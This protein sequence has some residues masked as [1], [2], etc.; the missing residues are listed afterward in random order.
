MALKGD[1][2][3]GLSMAIILLLI[4]FQ[5]CLSTHQRKLQGGLYSLHKSNEIYHNHD[6]LI[7]VLRHR[8]HKKSSLK[9]HWFQAPRR[10]S[11]FR[12]LRDPLPEGNSRAGVRRGRKP[13]L[14]SP[15]T[16]PPIAVGCGKGSLPM[17]KA[18]RKPRWLDGTSISKGAITPNTHLEWQD[19]MGWGGVGLCL[20]APLVGL[21]G[22]A[23]P[24]DVI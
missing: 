22:A 2:R 8:R 9:R 19:G 6:G 16:A 10:A 13:P 1:W 17:T 5:P 7:V 23:S 11:K 20:P 3:G 14:W 15:P 18:L 12:D 21:E 4:Q 24:L